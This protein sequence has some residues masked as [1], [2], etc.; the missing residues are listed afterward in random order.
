MGG[1]DGKSL[2]VII[3]VSDWSGVTMSV[4]G[5][6]DDG[7][8][9]WKGRLGSV[10]VLVLVSE[11]KEGKECFETRRERGM[12]EVKGEKRASAFVLCTSDTTLDRIH[13]GETGK[14][15]EVG[16]REGDKRIRK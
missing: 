6:D 4:F 9:N 15:D 2:S 11:R 12:I 13:D 7:E 1:S 3:D 5:V 10:L 16:W 8:G 14:V